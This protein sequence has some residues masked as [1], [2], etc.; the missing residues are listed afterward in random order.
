M[1]PPAGVAARS[2]VLPVEQWTPAEWRWATLQYAKDRQNEKQNDGRFVSTTSA[3]GG[4]PM[5]NIKRSYAYDFPAVGGG[6]PA[7]ERD[8]TRTR[9]VENRPLSS[10]Q[11]AVG[12]SPLASRAEL[13][14]LDVR[15]A[16]ARVRREREEQ[17]IGNYDVRGALARK[18][19]RPGRTADELQRRLEILEAKLAQKE[20][21]GKNVVGGGRSNVVSAAA[22]QNSAAGAPE[23]TTGTVGPG[24]V[25]GSEQVG[26]A[27]SSTAP[28]VP[29]S[30]ASGIV[31]EAF[32]EQ[33]SQPRA[34]SGAATFDGQAFDLA[35]G[36]L[37]TSQ[38]NTTNDPQG[39]R[40]TDAAGGAGGD[41]SA[42]GDSAA[43]AGAE[44]R[45]RPRSENNGKR[46]DLPPFMRVFNRKQLQEIAET[47]LMAARQR[48]Y[49]GDGWTRLPNQGGAGYSKPGDLATAP[50][51]L[52]GAK[53]PR[54]ERVERYAA[55]RGGREP[56]QRVGPPISS[57][58]AAEMM[59]A[60]R[61]L[62][63]CTSNLLGAVREL[64]EVA[65]N[66]PEMVSSVREEI[67]VDRERVLEGH[68]RQIEKFM[69][70]DSRMLAR[71][72]E[73]VGR[74]LL[75]ASLASINYLRA[76]EGLSGPRA[77]R[78]MRTPPMRSSRSGSRA[79]S[80]SS[81]IERRRNV[82]REVQ[83]LGRGAYS[84][85]PGIGGF[86]LLPSTPGSSRFA[87]SPAYSSPQHAAMGSALRTDE[88]FPP[89]E[90][91][92]PEEVIVIPGGGPPPPYQRQ[93]LAKAAPEVAQ[94]LG[95]Y[96]W[97]KAVAAAG[98]PSSGKDV[99]LGFQLDWLRFPQVKVSAV[100]SVSEKTVKANDV[101]LG[102]CD[103]LV[104]AV[105]TWPGQDADEALAAKIAA[106]GKAGN[107]VFLPGSKASE[108]VQVSLQSK[109]VGAHFEGNRIKAVNPLGFAA[110]LKLAVGDEILAAG[111]QETMSGGD[112]NSTLLNLLH[113]K[114][115][116]RPLSLLIRRAGGFP[117]ETTFYEEPQY[118]EDLPSEWSARLAFARYSKKQMKFSVISPTQP[119]PKVGG[120]SS[121]PPP[122]FLLSLL[123]Q[124]KNM[125]DH[126]ILVWSPA[127]TSDI[128]GICQNAGL[129]SGDKMLGCISFQM[130]WS[131]FPVVPVRNMQG[132]S[133][134]AARAGVANKDLVLMIN[135]ARITMVAT[136]K[137]RHPDDAVLR[138]L[139]E[140]PKT[141]AFMKQASAKKYVQLAGE[142]KA[143][144]L[145]DLQPGKT[146][147]VL[148][149]APPAGSWAAKVGLQKG[150][151]LIVAGDLLAEKN[152]QDAKQRA[153][154]TGPRPLQMLFR[155]KTGFPDAVRANAAKTK[156]EFSGA[157]LK[158]LA[159]RGLL[160]SK[161]L[162]LPARS[163]KKA[164]YQAKVKAFVGSGSPP[165]MAGV[166]SKAAAARGSSAG[167]GTSGAGSAAPQSSQPSASSSPSALGP[168]PLASGPR[169]V[170]PYCAQM[171]GLSKDMVSAG[172][173]GWAQASI[174]S[175]L[176]NDPSVTA[177][178]KMLGLFGMKLNWN[179]F[180]VVL[181]EEVR[182][183]TGAGGEPSRAAKNKVAVGDRLVMVGT[184]Q[185]RVTLVP[186]WAGKDPND[187]VIQ[188]IQRKFA[189][190]D[191][192]VAA[193]SFLR[194]KYANYYVQ[195]G[196][197]N[198]T[199]PDAGM[200]TA[201]GKIASVTPGGW[202][203]KTGLKVDDRV[204]VAH[205][206][207]RE[208]DPAEIDKRVAG[209]RPLQFL[210]RR[211]KD[212]P[213][214]VLAKA[215]NVTRDFPSNWSSKKQGGGGS[216]ASSSAAVSSPGIAATS[217]EVR[218]ANNGS[219]REVANPS[220]TSFSRAESSGRCSCS[221]RILNDPAISATD[222]MR[223]L[224]GMEL[225]WSAFPLVRVAK[226][227]PNLPDGSGPSRAAKNNVAVG[228][229]ALM[230]VTM[231]DRVTLVPTW[232]GK[233]PNDAVIQKVQ[234]KFAR[235]DNP[236]AA[237]VF[238]RKK[239]E[240]RYLQVV[241]NDAGDFGMQVTGGK[242]TGV[243]AGGKAAGV[244]LQPE[245]RIVVAHEVLR[246]KDAAE[247]D[248]R[249][250]AQGMR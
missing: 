113:P 231:Q 86:S 234:R 151:E 187:A 122:P 76:P 143:L 145:D 64:R 57:V 229:R 211:D 164:D 225:D 227:E 124:S 40:N 238:L 219:V 97:T 66:W 98:S 134:A 132:A 126:D 220:L 175:Q 117:A 158:E 155:R 3:S 44:T 33:R 12:V 118:S 144:G 190:K 88:R 166:V 51:M 6:G 1:D 34:V 200:K 115:G 141:W 226:V 24:F 217:A 119:P 191:N 222:K 114:R 185:E 11:Q 65:V 154:K 250:G 159:A 129:M 70:H 8:E 195:L 128:K 21:V 10:G 249:V 108:F 94:R 148:P 140:K 68:A 171:L 241:L 156:R 223:K 74:P 236:V 183:K 93:F 27:Q 100:P 111:D 85:I 237:F 184:L 224:F 136:F 37:G 77:E 89:E 173:C 79:L 233:D 150:D 135:E 209:L 239:Y 193:F 121:G 189:R 232:E 242:V 240:G 153:S 167:I 210:A 92:L 221:S 157:W 56:Q 81:S 49:D 246:E 180:P 60:V 58:E 176:L 109:R 127:G 207:L 112:D 120:S 168:A 186:T 102:C 204:I 142:D 163:A 63:E 31:D 177:E 78:H 110:R 205:D 107:F 80:T 9:V 194:Q 235:K 123:L 161:G 198:K 188:K 62:P 245:D 73:Q 216:K 29:Q 7:G 178:D 116:P 42:S 130:D 165:L 35:G 45:A 203:D 38:G 32:P 243:T 202:A 25:G 138:S 99:D 152:A 137:G 103:A 67:R 41:R 247:I 206:A 192:P 50:L 213:P 160:S 91:E 43:P 59:Q 61:N 71:Q 212:F 39:Q 125:K 149:A 2:P 228:D 19:T 95:V 106:D 75:G 82:P 96:S 139:Y 36:P 147:C 174:D 69:V 87:S 105:S 22:G 162:S 4:A 26:G 48:A 17:R 72:R 169:A 197:D 101:L 28:F 54:Q 55:L 104:S 182:P 214:E 46:R 20:L 13:D 199:L 244:G 90:L 83:T 201:N 53:Q 215:T 248:K 23:S 218:R 181:V 133:C 84:T 14:R 170:V 16:G 230:M 47:G 5:M 52:Y 172:L 30:P 208:K 18:F 146:S 131:D 15:G 179:A 196:L